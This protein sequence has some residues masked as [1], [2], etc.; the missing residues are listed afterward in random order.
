M[1]NITIT[2]DIGGNTQLDRRI[3]RSLKVIENDFRRSLS[4][5]ELAKHAGLSVFAFVRTFKRETGVS[6]WQCIMRC[7]IE[8]AKALLMG[9]RM[10]I[11]Q[12]CFE[13]GWQNVSHFT[14]V[15]RRL[16]GI[17]PGAF[18]ARRVPLAT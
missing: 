13:V 9:T 8:A 14:A 2:A 7:R 12:I 10:A 6:P 17:S 11:A 4:L 1:L 5:Q 18:R 3:E 15:F 16:V